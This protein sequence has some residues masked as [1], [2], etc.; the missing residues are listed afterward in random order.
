[1]TTPR[2]KKAKMGR[3]SKGRDAKTRLLVVKI[4]ANERAAWLKHAKA[5]GMPLGPWLLRP[6]R[7]ELEGS[8]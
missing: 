2:R 5:A 4:S 1:M 8:K 6:R 7:D 3:P